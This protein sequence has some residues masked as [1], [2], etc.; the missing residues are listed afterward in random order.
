[1]GTVESWV[2]T[3]SRRDDMTR[4]HHMFFFNNIICFTTNFVNNPE[5]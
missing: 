5:K 2:F 1:M 3:V 4:V